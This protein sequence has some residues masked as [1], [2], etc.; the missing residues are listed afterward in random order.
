M[1]RNI[2]PPLL[3]ALCLLGVLPAFAAEKDRAALDALAAGN[4]EFALDLYGRL[5]PEKGNLFFSPYSISTALAMTYGGARGDTAKQ[6]SDVLRFPYEDDA[7]HGAFMHMEK[8]LEATQKDGKI[9]LR[10]ANALWPHQ[11]YPF[12]KEFTAQIKRFYGVDI[13][14]VDYAVAREAARKRI[15]AW[16]ERMTEGKIKDLIPKGI[17]NALTRLVL[18]NAIYFKGDWRSQFKKAATKDAPFTMANGK[19]RQVPL[20]YQQEQFRYAELDGVQV[21]ELPYGDGELSMI[22]VLPREA[23]GLAGLE[24]KL[25]PGQLARWTGR[26]RKQ[27]VRVYLPRFEMTSQFS[28]N[29][30]LI[31]MGMRDAFNPAGNANFSG[32][33]ETRDLYIQAVLHKAFVAVDEK[34]TEAAAATAVV[35]G[36]RSAARPRP[37]PVFRADHPFL[38]T[39]RENSTGSILFMGR[40]SE[41]EE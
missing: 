16:A 9:A 3:T 23:D 8:Q 2:L 15:N 24:A 4:T 18:T 31:A 27:K 22:V 40:L 29:K 13:V 7:L 19:S 10:V 20:M 25:S 32:M 28:L 30:A 36:L 35:M 6:M 33:D 12:R 21:L 1:K 34:G 37:V 11:G 5:A 39:I 38:F 17:L 14:H 26:M 41:P